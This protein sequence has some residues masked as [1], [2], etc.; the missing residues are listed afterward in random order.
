MSI[1]VRDFGFVTRNPAEL[2]RARRIRQAWHSCHGCQ[3]VRYSVDILTD[4]MKVEEHCI[5]QPTSLQRIH[6]CNANLF[7]AHTVMLFMV[8]KEC[9]FCFASLGPSKVSPLCFSHVENDSQRY[10]SANKN[11]LMVGRMLKHCQRAECDIVGEPSICQ[12]LPRCPRWQI[13]VWQQALQFCSALF[14]RVLS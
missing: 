6:A 11:D 2:A 12:P 10:T 4:R 3:I 13:L 8:I 5:N 14:Q 1:K 9:L 7:A